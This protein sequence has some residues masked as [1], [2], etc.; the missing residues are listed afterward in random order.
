MDTLT[1]SVL[2]KKELDET[3]TNL[4]IRKLREK[5][6]TGLRIVAEAQPKDKDV[7]D[8]HRREHTRK[9]MSNAP[10][11]QHLKLKRAA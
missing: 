1:R 10:L 11:T 3:K 4:K 6:P 7:R 9:E 8:A 5:K 2:E